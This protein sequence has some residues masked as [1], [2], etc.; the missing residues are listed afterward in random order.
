MILIPIPENDFD[1]SEVSIPWRILTAKG[2][3]VVFATPLGKKGNADKRM[4]LGDGLGILKPI[5]RASGDARADYELLEKDQNFLKPI[6]YEKIEPNAYNGILLPGGHAK[7]M[8]PYL[9]S[10][11]LQ[12]IIVNFFD[13]KNQLV[14]FAMGYYLLQEASIQIQINQFYII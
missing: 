9:E 13:Q 14:L 12:S 10:K 6:S 4:L 2:H 3:K 8:I 11:I 5:L 7:G 1:P